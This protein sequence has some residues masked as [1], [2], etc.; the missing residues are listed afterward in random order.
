MTVFLIGWALTIAYLV[1]NHE[2]LDKVS[3][4]IQFVW[5]EAALLS[6]TGGAV[7]MLYTW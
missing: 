7:W 1:A 2:F 4:A 5:V 3:I 6:I